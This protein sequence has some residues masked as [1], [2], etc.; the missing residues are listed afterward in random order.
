MVG[1]AEVCFKESHVQ[2]TF[3]LAKGAA[4]S[5][6]GAPLRDLVRTLKECCHL[7]VSHGEDGGTSS[8]AGVHDVKFA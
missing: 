7:C 3:L 1:A 5:L 2:D 6:A 4:E 8:V